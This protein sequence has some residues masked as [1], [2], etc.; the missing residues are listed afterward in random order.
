MPY[1]SYPKHYKDYRKDRQKTLTKRNPLESII[2]PLTKETIE[3]EWE[4]QRGKCSWAQDPEVL[5]FRSQQAANA[6]LREIYQTEI[7]CLSRTIEAPLYI[8]T[9]SYHRT[10]KGSQ[11]F[12]KRASEQSLP[13]TTLIEK[14]EEPYYHYDNKYQ[15]ISDRVYKLK[16]LNRAPTQALR[17]AVYK[18]CP[19]SLLPRHGDDNAFLRMVDISSIDAHIE[20]LERYRDRIS[21]QFED[22]KYFYRAH[23]YDGPNWKHH[24]DDL[25]DDNPYKPFRLKFEAEVQ[26]L[27]DQKALHEAKLEKLQTRWD[28]YY[29]DEKHLEAEQERLDKKFRQRAERR[30]EL[31]KSLREKRKI[32]EAAAHKAL[33]EQVKEEMTQWRNDVHSGKKPCG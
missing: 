19:T 4:H 10:H 2:N 23:E 20:S 16:V 6:K 33:I 18:S 24:V 25:S 1:S 7:K 30:A 22:F 17:T 26:K 5:M 13:L 11:A 32:R 31:R 15:G 8:K 28:D 9:D 21:E 14:R 29:C 27:R 12:W 3:L